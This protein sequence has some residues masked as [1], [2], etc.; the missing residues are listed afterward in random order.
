VKRF[1]TKKA[2]LK[3]IEDGEYQGYTLPGYALSQLK[4]DLA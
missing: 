2:V 3:A 4:A 1:K